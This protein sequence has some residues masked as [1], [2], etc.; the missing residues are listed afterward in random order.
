MCAAAETGSGKTGAFGLPLLQLI[1]ESLSNSPAA[2]V[3]VYSQ[4]QLDS[5]VGFADHDR[6]AMV[7][8]SENNA[9]AEGSNATGWTGSRCG[10]GVK[11]GQYAFEFHVL[12]GLCRLG[13]SAT[14]SKSFRLGEDRS[15]FG[16]GG[17]GK[18]AFDKSFSDYGDAFQPGDVIGVLIDRDFETI[19][20]AKN[21]VNLG[22]AFDVGSWDVNHRYRPI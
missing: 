14:G 10:L 8:L 9:V 1:H 12:S 3:G 13:L 17:T 16:F 15:S 11:K 6:D 21:G 18:K 2:M 7:Q 4:T 20:F 22:K 5:N 19:N